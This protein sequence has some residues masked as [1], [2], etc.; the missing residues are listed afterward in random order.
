MSHSRWVFVLGFAMAAAHGADLT[1]NWLAATPNGDGTSRKL[2]FHVKQ[3]GD[4]ITGTIRAGQSV[5]TISNSEGGPE[6][7]TLTGTVLD[8]GRER[9]ATFEMIVSGDTVSFAPVR[10]GAAGV[11]IPAHR[12][13]DSDGALPPRVT[14]PA[15]HQVPDNGLARTPPMGWNSWNKFHTRV[16]DEIVRGVA[17]AIASN[18]MRDAGYVYITI[19]DTWEGERDANGVLHSNNKFPDM[20][21]LA[22][23]V[24]R[25]GLKLGIYSG[26]GPTTCEGYEASGGHEEQDAKTFAAWG[27]DY[28]KYDWCGARMLHREAEEQAVY[29]I[30]GD[31]LAASGRKIVFSLCQYG[32]DEVWKWGPKVGGNLWRTTGDIS[33]RWESMDR[34]GFSQNDLA[35]YAG[36]GHWN[37]P[38]ML[39]VGNGGMTDTEYRTHFSLWS[40]LAAPLIA[41][42]DVREMTPAIREI[43]LNRDVIAI[44][45]DKL[46]KQAARAWKSGE[47]EI[48][49]RPLANGDTAVALFNRGKDAASITVHWSELG[50]NKPPSRARD[51]WLHQEVK[52]AGARYTSEVPSHG[53]VLLRVRH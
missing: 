8:E 45:Q 48:W 29:Q 26:P 46:G 51:L 53:V 38:D 21:A 31:A 1:G 28:L 10:N 11:P 41:G 6:R 42:N 40:M 18:G 25:K 14:P 34:I 13:P 24:H 39:E 33:D 37:D 22:D 12:V 43:L 9:R 4:R 27:I 15:L 20:K 5:Y 2:W 36:P 3:E 7:Y 49:T 47:Q 23:Y 19:D 44:D 32:R 17:D 52:L 50:M 16:S 35:P 30:M